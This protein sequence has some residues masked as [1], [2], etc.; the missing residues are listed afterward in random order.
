MEPKSPPV[1]LPPLPERKLPERKLAW[2]MLLD[3]E[4]NVDALPER[5]GEHGC[6][7]CGGAFVEMTA[8]AYEGAL[9]WPDAYGRDEDGALMVRPEPQPVVAARCACSLGHITIV[10]APPSWAAL[11][12]LGVGAGIMAAWYLATRVFKGGK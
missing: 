8:V 10:K 6:S 1:E 12:A 7:E 5:W 2:C 3:E 4:A 11:G 9:F